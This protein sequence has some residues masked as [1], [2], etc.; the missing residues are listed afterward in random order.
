MNMRHIILSSV[1]FVV[2]VPVLLFIGRGQ[3]NLAALIVAAVFG[4]ILFRRMDLWWMVA[5]VSVGS[6]IFVV[7]ENASLRLIASFAFVALAILGVI[8]TQGRGSPE[9]SLPKSAAIGLVLVLVLTA[10]IRGWGL[11]ILGGTHWGGT[12]YIFVIIALLYFVFSSRVTLSERQI[13]LTARWFCLLGLLPAALTIAQHMGVPLG[14]MRYFFSV[15]GDA[16]DAEM[17]VHAVSRFQALQLPAAHM[18][19]FALLLFDRQF[20]LTPAV[21]VAAGLSFTFLGLSGHRTMVVLLG[22]TVLIYLMIRRGT[23][24]ARYYWPLVFA[25][26]VA[27]LLIYAFAIHLPIPFQRALSVLPGLRVDAVAAMDAAATTEWR[28]EMWRELITMIPTYLLVGR[29]LGFDLMEA[30]AAY[31][32]AA[33]YGLHQFM[34]ATH[35]YHSGPLWLLIDM[36]LAGLIFGTLVLFGGAWYYG[37]RMREIPDGTLFQTVYVVFYSYFF[38]YGIFFFT[39]IGSHTIVPRI[40]MAAAVLEVVLQSVRKDKK[41]KSQE[42]TS[43]VLAMPPGR[44]P[45]GALARGLPVDWPVR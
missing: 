42:V 29:G 45:R 6:G 27:L 19:V 10:T 34:I 39:V 24:V 5:S 2:V 43:E 32:L 22:L 17:A 13:W 31:T 20:R 9:R 4:L 37:K 8:M 7:N 3:F 41:G 40:M 21:I 33:D 14:F 26:C 16:S 23:G 11:R 28:I 1:A 38:A 35:M 25:M 12:Q 44:V 18:G 30:Y 36:G 15:S